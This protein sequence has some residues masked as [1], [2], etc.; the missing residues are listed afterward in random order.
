[1]RSL[2]VVKHMLVLIQ[3]FL[4]LQVMLNCTATAIATATRCLRA[5]SYWHYPEWFHL[6]DEIAARITRKQWVNQC[7]TDVDIIY[8]SSLHDVSKHRSRFWWFPVYHTFLF[9]RFPH[10]FEICVSFHSEWNCLEILSLDFLMR[11]SRYSLS[12]LNVHK[13][14]C[15]AFQS[16][17]VS[18]DAEQMIHSSLNPDG[19]P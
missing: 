18:A 8:M 7:R 13:I 2:F 10:I 6:V 9:K 11:D 5:S 1:M 17:I 3:Y 15:K 12:P 14:V 4:I 16:S 19:L